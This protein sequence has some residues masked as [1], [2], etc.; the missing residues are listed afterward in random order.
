MQLFAGL[1]RLETTKFVC[2][3]RSQGDDDSAVSSHG[4]A[5]GG[6][7]L[8]AACDSDVWSR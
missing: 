1:I 2:L 7:F 3:L 6:K 4:V 5:T 8:G